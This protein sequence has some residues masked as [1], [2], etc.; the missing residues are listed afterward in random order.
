MKIDNIKEN[1]II[2][3]LLCDGNLAISGRCINTHYRENFSPKQLDYLIW[4]YKTLISLNFKLYIRKSYYE[5][6]TPSNLLYTYYYN[7]FYK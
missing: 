7:L 3:S 1:I 4:R 5:L 2:G 6:T